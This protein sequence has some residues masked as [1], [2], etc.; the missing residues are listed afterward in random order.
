[1]SKLDAALV[2]IL[3]QPRFNI[4]PDESHQMKNQSDLRGEGRA[5]ND[6]E[7]INSAYDKIERMNTNP[8]KVSVFFGSAD[9]PY[10]RLDPYFMDPLD[11]DPEAQEAL[12]TLINLMDESLIDL[13]LQPG[14]FC[15]IDNYRAVH[16][17]K[18]FKARYDGNDRWIKRISMT[19]D[20]RKSRRWR[21]STTSRLIM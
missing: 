11:D 9:A 2:D 6:K 19:R 5:S 1:V 21:A 4:R 12:N 13:V 18:P 8:E 16:G 3:F 20:L 15:F 17:R 10:L 7:S 14:E